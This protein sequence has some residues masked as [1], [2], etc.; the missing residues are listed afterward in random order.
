M[1]PKLK[2]KGVVFLLLAALIA[3]NFIFSS[4]VAANDGL[5]WTRYIG[6]DGDDELHSSIY[7]SDNCLLLVGKSNSF[8]DDDFD[9][10]IVKVNLNGNLLWNITHS[11]P[12]LSEDDAAYQ[13]IETSDGYIITGKISS[14]DGIGDDVLLLK[15]DKNGNK[16]WSKNIG[17]NSW[18]WGNDL[19]QL[20]DNSILVLAT[21]QDFFGFP[22]D[23][24]LLKFDSNG[25]ELWKKRYKYPDHQY[26]TSVI[27][28]SNQNLYILGTTSSTTNSNSSI[29]LIKTD[30]S[31]QEIWYKEYG[32]PERETAS[33]IVPY[34]N[35]FLITGTTNSYGAG[36]N[37]VY[38]FKIDVNGNTL[39]EKTIG[40]SSDDYAEN[41]IVTSGTI[42]LTCNTFKNSGNS[43][44]PY[45][46]TLNQNGET[47]FNQT[48]GKKGY[49]KAIKT[50]PI[51]QNTYYITGCKGTNNKD[52]SITKINLETHNLRVE[53]TVGDPYGAGNYYLG[54]TPSFG[55]P[56]ETVYDGNHVRYLFTGWTS[57]SPGGY[58]GPNNP[59]KINIQNDITQTATWQKQFYVEIQTPIGSTTSVT[60]GWFN[61]EEQI[62]IHTSID[63]GFT[64][65][66][67]RTETM[68][69]TCFNPCFNGSASR[70]ARPVVERIIEL[71]FQSLF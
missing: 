44:D 62:T 43:L 59:A 63:D 12:A 41:I 22:Y 64:F 36:R 26:P 48:Y 11:D 2:E 31:G 70:T 5:E 8:T 21:T 23:P 57:T 40:S 35:G 1:F 18:D 14:L 45:L 39:W 50:H 3:L 47:T 60:S 19:I 67:A 20:P 29:F 33:K 28:D 34:N 27:R 49:E 25:N 9:V 42:I 53:S 71:S 52:F 10:Y 66:R 16:L 30:Y 61:E 24:W 38:V 32:G 15:L 13:A 37:D 51:N 17:W 4:Y 58:N 56:E 65:A 46:V 68:I 54:A 7:T 55:V 69:S 6:G